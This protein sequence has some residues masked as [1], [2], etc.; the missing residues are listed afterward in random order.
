MRVYDALR[1]LDILRRLDGVDP[2]WIA[3]AGQGEMAVVALYAA[4]LDGEVQTL[5]LG[6]P[7]GTQ[8]APSAPDGTGPAIE[9]LNSLRVA[10]LPTIAA[11][12][13]PATL[14]F[15]GRPSPA[16][17][18]TEEVYARLGPPGEIHHANRNLQE[19]RPK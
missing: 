19:W 3:L 11:L 15:V 18:W 12:L 4:L 13:Y 1:G 8:D 16:Y 2:H 10:D 9:M 17:G 6:E 14:V 7:P 5:F